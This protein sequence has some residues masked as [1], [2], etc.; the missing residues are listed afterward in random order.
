MGQEPLFWCKM[1]LNVFFFWLDYSLINRH[2]FHQSSTY[3]QRT[4][5]RC[6]A[7][8]HLSIF[9]LLSSD[10]HVLL[11]SYLGISDHLLN[12][13]FFKFDTIP[14]SVYP[15]Y[16]SDINHKIL[17]KQF[18]KWRQNTLIIFPPFCCVFSSMLHSIVVCVWISV[19]WSQYLACNHVDIIHL[20]CFKLGFLNFDITDILGQIV[21]CCWGISCAL[22]EISHHPSLLPT[23]CQ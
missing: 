2:L 8:N 18:L 17:R 13:I 20:P 14:G 6:F 3:F 11:F 19:L 12:F 15:K 1:T 7:M 10:L 9:Y 5:P 23:R 4:F 21:L 22:W 16:A